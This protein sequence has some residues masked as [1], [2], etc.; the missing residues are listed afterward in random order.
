MK[1]KIMQELQAVVNALNT[2]SVSGKENL[3][4]LGGSI[5]RVGK[6]LWGAFQRRSKGACKG[7]GERLSGGEKRP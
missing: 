6:H 2:I 3:G 5:S 7:K 1:E 4:K